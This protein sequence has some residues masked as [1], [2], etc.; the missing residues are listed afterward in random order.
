MELLFVIAKQSF[1]NQWTGIVDPKQRI[2][3]PANVAKELVEMGLVDLEEP[4]EEVK[5]KAKK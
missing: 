4:A 1:I 2:S 3:L 5:P